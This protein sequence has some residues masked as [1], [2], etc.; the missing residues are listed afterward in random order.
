MP[1][2]RDRRGL[3]RFRSRCLGPSCPESGD[4]SHQYGD[5]GNTSNSKDY[6]VKGGNGRVVVRRSRAL[7][8][9]INRHE[10]AIGPAVGRRANVRAGRSRASWPTTSTTV[11]FLWEQK[12]PGA[13]RTGV[14]NNED[15]S[16]LVATEDALFVC[17]RA[18]PARN[19][20]PPPAKWCAGTSHSAK[21]DDDRNR[22]WGYRGSRGWK[23]VRHQHRP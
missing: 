9:M 10:G 17:A 8:K 18:I 22:A 13:L 5:P 23:I 20:T 15:T 7:R 19:T 4:W 3:K 6:R 21:A 1:A 14:F 11:C 16:N 12:N 2:F